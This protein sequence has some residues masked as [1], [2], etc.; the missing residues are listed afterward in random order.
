MGAPPPEEAILV[1]N[2]DQPRSAGTIRQVM[3]LHLTP[4]Y[5]PLPKVDL[6]GSLP[7]RTCLITIPTYRGKG[8]HPI[9]L[10]TSLMAELMDISEDSLGLKAVVREHEG[11]TQR[12]E[13]DSPEILLDLNTPKDYQ[14]ALEMFVS[15]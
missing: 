10:S 7:G 11:E 3:E 8:G 1:L 15:E 6:G 12:V 14:K 9:I 2:V 13:I 5:P 4:L